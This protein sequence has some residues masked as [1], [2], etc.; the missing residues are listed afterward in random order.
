MSDASAPVDV[1]VRVPAA[2]SVARAIDA[3]AVGIDPASLGLTHVPA[4]PGMAFGIEADVSVFAQGTS[5]PVATRHL[6]VPGLDFDRKL[7]VSWSTG[8]DGIP[9]PGS[10]YVVE[11]RLRLFQTAGPP[12]SPSPRGWDPPR[13]TVKVLWER[14]LRQAEE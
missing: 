2:L 9:A 6:V 1:P 7:D 3:I 11:M 5:D 10:K 12:P 13:A 4:D 14:A 8:R